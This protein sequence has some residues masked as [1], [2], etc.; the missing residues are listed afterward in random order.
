MT[1]NTRQIENYKKFDLA[2]I[3]RK[4]EKN[5]VTKI[6][7]RFEA[8]FD[9]K[10]TDVPDKLYHITIKSYLNEILKKGLSPKE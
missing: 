7:L 6:E 1:Y 4:I 9:E 3:I 8:Y 2:E 5:I 10:E